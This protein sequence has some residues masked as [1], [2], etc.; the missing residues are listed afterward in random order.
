M[1]KTFLFA[2]IFVIVIASYNRVTADTTITNSLLRIS[3]YLPDNWVVYDENDSEMFFYDTSFAY[4]SQIAI[5][6][7]NRNMDDYLTPADWVRA[8]FIAYLFVV[9]YSWDPFGVVLYFDSSSACMQDSN[10][11]A[12]AFSEFYTIDTSIGSWDEYIRY[13]AAENYGYE[14]YA[15]GDTSDMKTNIGV[16][17]AIIKSIRITDS[18]TASKISGKSISSGARMN[19]SANVSY[20]YNI[21]GRKISAR[22]HSTSGAYLRPSS[23]KLFIEAK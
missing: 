17:M 18:S 22:M 13:T 21:L 23:G 14:I 15:I 6:K 7:Y 19:T 16:Y 2:I 10:W 8:H 12:E 4:R 20:R 9:E 3:A 5:K 1:R 11:A